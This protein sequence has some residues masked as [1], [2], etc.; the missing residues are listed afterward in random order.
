MTTIKKGDF[1]ALQFIGKIAD[2]GDVF[3]LTK[4]A[5]AKAAGIHKD[6]IAYGPKIICVGEYQIVK[7]V[8]DFLMG[9]EVGKAYTVT[10]EPEQ[11]FG[12]KDAKLMKLV[13]I[14]TFKK[15]NI[16]PFPG[17][18]LNIDGRLGVVRIVAGGRITV[19]FNHP[20]AG[21]TVTYK[22]TVERVVTDTKEKLD[23]FLTNIFNNN[24]T[25]DVKDGV[26]T[27]NLPIPE[28][29]HKPLNEHLKKI[30]PELKELK[31][32]Q[33]KPADKQDSATPQ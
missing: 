31:F 1:I 20:L 11:A 27:V 14:S 32:V 19:D 25:C 3:D 18:Q 17:L 16:K 23:N 21:R 22:L 12:K 5:D 2:T 30:I 6:N 15:Q 33:P 26:A 8:D 24:V 29:M 7:G 28:Q 10:L 9:K 4:E 13:P